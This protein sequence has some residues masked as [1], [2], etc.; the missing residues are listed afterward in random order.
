MV[1][2]LRF[3]VLRPKQTRNSYAKPAAAAPDLAL[4]LELSGDTVQVVGP[5]AKLARELRNRD[6]GAGLDRCQR[7][8]R[9]RGARSS[10]TLGGRAPATRAGA[11]GGSSRSRPVGGTP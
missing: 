9:P 7:L 1:Q 6:A 5:D 8:I 3:R 4:L 11:L 10:P 2:R